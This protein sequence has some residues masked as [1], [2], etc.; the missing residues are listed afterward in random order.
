M[1]KRWVLRVGA[2][3]DHVAPREV[4]GTVITHLWSILGNNVIVQS[5]EMVESVFLSLT[6]GREYTLQVAD[7]SEERSG[8]YIS[9][10]I[11]QLS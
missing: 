3:L 9:Y 4:F 6:T 7:L 5:R 8:A 11:V 10:N 2:T 1:V